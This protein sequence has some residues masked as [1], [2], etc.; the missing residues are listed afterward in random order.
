[1]TRIPGFV[2]PPAPEIPD[3]L[4]PAERVCLLRAA[5]VQLAALQSELHRLEELPAIYAAGPVEVAQE[6]LA[7]LARAVGWLHRTRARGPPQHN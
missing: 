2:G 6:E 7:C 3:E 5:R 1:M 4:G